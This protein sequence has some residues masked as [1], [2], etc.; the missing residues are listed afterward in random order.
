MPTVPFAPAEEVYPSLNRGDRGVCH[1]RGTWKRLSSLDFLLFALG[2]ALG[3]LRIRYWWLHSQTAPGPRQWPADASLPELLLVALILGCVYVGPLVLF[4]DYAI[5]GRRQ[6]PEIGELLWLG[7]PA[8]VSVRYI[9]FT[10]ADGLDASA[11]WPLALYYMW[12][13]ATVT[14]S[15]IAVSVLCAVVF[16]M[17]AGR[18]RRW[19]ELIGCGSCA[20]YGAFQVYY[21]I[22]SPII[23]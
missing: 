1:A 19:T 17:L 5:R 23:I 11:I 2:V 4:V 16:D 14:L 18:V 22:A 7:P 13:G 12:V 21:L 10:I 15:L 20:L 8:S 9:A 3:S 6:R